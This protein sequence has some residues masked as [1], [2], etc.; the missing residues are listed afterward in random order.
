M[1]HFVDL[2]PP[3]DL[4]QKT[5]AFTC[6]LCDPAAGPD[7]VFQT[8]V[9]QPSIGNRKRI[10]YSPFSAELPENILHWQGNLWSPKEMLK[11]WK[12]ALPT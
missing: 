5:V 7:S 12:N 6:K 4:M 8:V 10:I 3:F 1:D 11:S 2:P 9:F